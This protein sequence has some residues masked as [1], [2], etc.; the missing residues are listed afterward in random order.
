MGGVSDLT[1]K[2]APE[3]TRAE[4]TPLDPISG[5][6][7][8]RRNLLPRLAP[9]TIA[10][11]IFIALSA[12]AAVTSQ[13]FLDNDACTHYIYARFAFQEPYYF[14]DVWGRPLVTSIY[15]IP[16]WT[17]GRLGVRLTS[18]AVAVGTGLVT[19]GIARRQGYR[20]PVLALIFVL[21]QPIF[22][23]HSFAELTE[24]PF[25]FL[26]AVGFLAYQGR[27]WLGV[28]LVAG[29]MPTA[30][31]E[32]FAFLALAAAGLI[33]HRKDWWLPVLAA[34]GAAIVWAMIRYN[35]TT[36]PAYAIAPQLLPQVLA[37]LAGVALGFVIVRRAWW[38]PIL[39]APLA[40]WSIAGWFTNGGYWHDRWFM[41]ILTWIPQNWPYQARSEYP[42]GW[43]VHFLVLLPAV[44]SPLVFPAVVLGTWRSLKQGGSDDHLR[45]CH[46]LI[47]AV[48]LMV[49]AGHSLLYWR[50]WMASNGELR[51]MLV[52]T[53]F[54]GLLA[55][56]GWQWAFER[57]GLSKPLIWAAAAAL[58]PVLANL[59]YPIVPLRPEP[60]WSQAKQAEQWYRG[61]SI[62]ADYPR[63][64]STHRAVNYLL[65]ISP[66]DDQRA[67][68]YT[69]EEIL[70]PRPGT[71]L[72]WD[73]R[74]GTLNSDKDLTAE[75][76]VVLKAGWVPIAEF[77]R[78]D[79][80]SPGTAQ[81]SNQ[82][83]LIIDR[84]ASRLDTDERGNWYAFLSPQDRWGRPTVRKYK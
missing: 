68:E 31:P 40:A 1:R 80:R 38:L 52:V 39:L 69:H 11:A 22:F 59:A 43:L 51:Y 6:P 18:M 33:V 76:S 82:A 55:A 64:M 35:P 20:W 71:L 34:T 47:A 25:A 29:L 74:H 2:L 63:L 60:E 36:G 12:A 83:R 24:V 26:M 41:N 48:P 28:A 21:C 78:Q 16:A 17:L 73:P 10:V 37:A 62:T 72:I 45:R 84:L 67:A 77:R 75:L 23:L 30:R 32:G 56:L 58:M 13:G 49:L 61:A 15:A 54:W 57:L 46:W 3:V 19:M 5:A 27:R 50:G 53:P 79:Q 4:V 14:T 65:D 8:A 9:Q 81:A 42:D 44:V 7:A 66:T 70:K